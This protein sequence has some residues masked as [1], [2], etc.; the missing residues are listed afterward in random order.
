MVFMRSAMVSPAPHPSW[1]PKCLVALRKDLSR[2]GVVNSS[3]GQWMLSTCNSV[4]YLDQTLARGL[5]SLMSGGRVIELGAGC[6]CYTG[7]L[8][9][10]GM[11]RS[12]LAYDGGPNIGELTDNLV[13][14][15]DLTSDL[16]SL[17]GPHEWTLCLEVG[18]HIPKAYEDTLFANIVAGNPQGIVLS[19]AV[20]G[21]RGTG[22]V[23]CKSNEDV[24]LNMERLGFRHQAD[25]SRELRAVSHLPWFKKTL[26]VFTRSAGV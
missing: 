3:A 22:H 24:I 1:R 6:G 23:N 13:R 5:S 14:T 15:A 8:L 21:Q 19:W 18:E 20:L 17:I 26:M 12:V 16:S 4:H 9:D 10:Q 11:V 25:R 2:H 7:A